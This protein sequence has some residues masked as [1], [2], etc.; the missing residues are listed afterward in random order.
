V[1]AVGDVLTLHDA[2]TGAS[3]KNVTRPC[4]VIAVASTIV[5]VAPR[6]VSVSGPVPTPI[7]ASPGFSKPGSFSRWRRPVG[8]AAAEAAPNHGQLA[9]PYRGQVLALFSRKRSSS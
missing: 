3:D 4:M 9:E 6:S 7:S 5:V 1:I 2:D 8:R